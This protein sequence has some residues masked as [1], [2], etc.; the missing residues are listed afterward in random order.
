MNRCSFGSGSET[1]RDS[2]PAGAGAA[3]VAALAGL[4]NTLS[5][6]CCQEPGGH[7]TGKLIVLLPNLERRTI[8]AP[9]KII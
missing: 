3:A 7:K 5:W 2:W 1:V 9:H 6:P 8:T 4:A